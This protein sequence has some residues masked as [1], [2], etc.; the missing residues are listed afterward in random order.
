MQVEACAWPSIHGRHAGAM[1]SSGNGGGAR[2]SFC[3]KQ[4]SSSGHGASAAESGTDMRGSPGAAPTKSAADVHFTSVR[5]EHLLWALAAKIR[6]QNQGALVG[7]MPK[8][9]KR[10]RTLSTKCGSS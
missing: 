10:M 7:P 2:R 4:R 3:R 5:G 6:M 8:E 1:T 9:P